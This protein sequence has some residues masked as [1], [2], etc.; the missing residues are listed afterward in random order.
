MKRNLIGEKFNRLTVLELYD[1]SLRKNGY[2]VNLFKCICDCGNYKIVPQDYLTCNETRSCGC[3]RRKEIGT[4]PFNKLY[5]TYKKEA[6]KRKYVW[7]LNKDNFRKLTK[8][9][10]YYCNIEPLQVL[11]AHSKTTIQEWV[12]FNIYI[13]NGI[14]RLNNNDGYTIENYVTCCKFCNRAKRDYTVKEFKDWVN[15]VYQHW[16]SK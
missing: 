9:N 6:L 14:D 8:Q 5:G 3:L 12:D 15:N 11:K 4:A 1:K 7:N 10:C 13:Y 16:A 2:Y